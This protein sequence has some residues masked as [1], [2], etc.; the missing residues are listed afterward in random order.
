MLK[1]QERDNNNNNNNNTEAPVN[2]VYYEYFT[3]FDY[4][5]LLEP[6]GKV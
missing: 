4:Y 1:W 3:N 6:T 2:W 5:N